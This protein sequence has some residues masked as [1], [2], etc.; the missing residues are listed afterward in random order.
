MSF[1]NRIALIVHSCTVRFGGQPNK[2][3]GDA[4]LC[5]WKLANSHDEPHVENYIHPQ[6]GRSNIRFV[7]DNVALVADLALFCV[8]KILAKVNSY[9]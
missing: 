2:N 4:F 5:V 9:R 3:V 1:V 7:R 6:G 8:L